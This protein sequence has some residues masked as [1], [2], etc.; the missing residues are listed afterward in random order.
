MREHVEVVWYLCSTWVSGVILV[1]PVGKQDPRDYSSSC[2]WPWGVGGLRGRG[3]WLSCAMPLAQGPRVNGALS[4]T[5]HCLWMPFLVLLVWSFSWRHFCSLC[6]LVSSGLV[7]TPLLVASSLPR[8][9]AALFRLVPGTAKD[10]TG[11]P[12]LW[13]HC[14]VP[15]SSLGER[16]VIWPFKSDLQQ[17]LSWFVTRP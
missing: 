9:C 2:C 13:K 15:G 16:S 12:V 5:S 6:V 4:Q 1:L 10:G 11:E 14:A 3:K 17:L 7:T 8:G